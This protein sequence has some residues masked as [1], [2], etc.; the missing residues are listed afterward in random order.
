M[1]PRDGGHGDGADEPQ[2][3][4]KKAETVAAA[5]AYLQKN[6]IVAYVQD[7]L[8]CVL[9]ARPADPYDYISAHAREAFK[10]MNAMSKVADQ[11]TS[12]PQE[13]TRCMDVT[14]NEE[15]LRPE[16]GCKPQQPTSIRPASDVS[17]SKNS[18]MCDMS[19]S[20]SPESDI[21]FDM[22]AGATRF[23]DLFRE[24]SPLD[25]R[26]SPPPVPGGDVKGAPPPPLPGDDMKKAPPP[27]VPADD[28]KAT[29]GPPP[30]PPERDLKASAPEVS[31]FDQM[32]KNGDGVVSREEFAEALKQPPPSAPEPTSKAVCP[33]PPAE[34]APKGKSTNA[35]ARQG[36]MGA[37]RNGQLENLVEDMEATIA[38]KEQAE[39]L[40]P[41][42]PFVRLPSGGS[43][44]ARL[45][46]SPQKEEE[47][48]EKDHC[49]ISFE[50]HLEKRHLFA[51]NA[52]QQNDLRHHIAENLGCD[53]VDIV[54]LHDGSVVAEVHAVGFIHEDHAQESVRRINDFHAISKQEYGEYSVSNPPALFMKMHRASRWLR[55]QMA[56]SPESRQVPQPQQE[57]VTAVAA[58]LFEQM[59]KNKDG[60]I[61]KEEFTQSIQ[62]IEL[63]GQNDRL[64]S[65]NENLRKEIERL[66]RSLGVDSAAGEA[67]QPVLPP[68]QDFTTREQS[69]APEAASV[70]PAALGTTSQAMSAAGRSES[71]AR[72]VVGF[73]CLLVG[74][75][76]E[77]L[78]VDPTPRVQLEQRLRAELAAR[79]G[80]PEG[81]VDMILSEGPIKVQAQIRSHDAGAVHQRLVESSSGRGEDDLRMS[82]AR[83][84]AGSPGIVARSASPVE[85]TALEVLAPSAAGSLGQSSPPIRQLVS[86]AT[87]L[88][89]LDLGFD[90]ALNGAVS[91][92]Y[93]ELHKQNLNLRSAN[94]RLTGEFTTLKSEREHMRTMLMRLCYGLEGMAAD[95]RGATS[96]MQIKPP[97]KE[98]CLESENRTLREANNAL[99][100]VNKKLRTENSALYSE[101]SSRTASRAPSQTTASPL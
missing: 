94:T 56:A 48:E 47:E 75:D 38:C 96:E 84:A 22:I 99:V 92:L 81:D 50:V 54:R 51:F 87:R 31:T 58:D 49:A 78:R 35:R 37:F 71:D 52:V 70:P 32:D 30:P 67:A 8:A 33:R 64:M 9:K 90:D 25:E 86:T 19:C 45:W 95:I 66:R 11:D 73:R 80:V 4:A 43:W 15:D 61:S 88:P 39:Q 59:D 10:Q 63:A 60:V 89:G 2:D 79:A 85:A 17:G 13:L 100:Q 23:S 28:M 18:G 5:R 26:A 101:I 76:N 12:S 46:S 20:A 53:R 93:E 21:A 98:S 44:C 1:T 7:V 69:A 42:R 3:S 41:K 6:N 77:A 34:S 57:A 24:A 91:D 83:A 65:A 29:S 40:D 36:L 68:Q 27:P 14:M 55:E 72:S 82:L 74:V 16:A 97:P 62:D